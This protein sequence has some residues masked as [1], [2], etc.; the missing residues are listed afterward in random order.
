MVTRSLLAAAL[1]ASTAW[2]GTYTAADCNRSS[3]N[4]VINGPTHNAVS[5]DIIL[6]PSGTCTWTSGIVVTANITIQG[7]GTPN[8]SPSQFG[9]GTI[10]TVLVYNFSSASLITAELPYSSGALFRLSTLDI[11]PETGSTTLNIPVS[12]V[13]TC[14]SS[15]CP[16]VRLDNLYLGQATAFTAS[17]GDKPLIAIDDVFGVIDHCSDNTNTVPHFLDIEHSNYLGDTETACGGFGCGDNSWAQPDTFGTASEMYVENNSLNTSDAFVDTEFYANGGG[18]I[19]GGRFVFRFNHLNLPQNVQPSGVI[20]AHGLDTNGRPQGVRHVEAYGNTANNTSLHSAGGLVNLRSGTSILFGNTLEASGGGSNFKEALNFV[21][22]RNVYTNPDG[23]GACGGSSVYDTDD[24][25]TYYSGTTTGGSSALIMND[26]TQ[27]WTTNQ[28]APSGSP[29]SVY[30]TSQGFW[31]EIASNTST[32]ITIQA[33]IPEQTNAFSVGDSYQILRATVCADQGGRGAGGYVDGSTPTPASAL[34]QA[35]DPAYEWDD[36]YSATFSGQ[37]GSNVSIFSTKRLIANRDYY[38]DGSDGA[39]VAQT[40]STS[41][42]NG[43]SGVGF[44]ILARRPSTCTPNV[45]YFATD[46]GSWNTS[47]NGFGSGVFYQCSS[48]N[49]WTTYYTPYVY[50]HPLAATAGGGTVSANGT[51]MANGVVRQ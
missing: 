25:T 15:S 24:G 8:T 47:G 5:G 7:N 21:V 1:F 42:F 14:S 38:T 3:V 27:S 51:V 20:D 18:G 30:D 35:L 46:Q 37:G 33:N 13:G 50:P 19:G 23:W 22:Y 17:N 44:G 34:S 28:L 48:T 4:A 12:V 10:N 49:T 40:S 11:E 43:T 2:A 26:T 9:A 45:G 6:I 31:A 39:P 41:P 36:S 32:S 16:S 29:Y